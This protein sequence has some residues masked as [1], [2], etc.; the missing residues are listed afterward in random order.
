MDWG[1]YVARSRSSPERLRT[2][3][4]G[5]H[6]VGGSGPWERSILGALER[7]TEHGVRSTEHG[8]LQ[9][10]PKM[11]R[12]RRGTGLRPGERSLRKCPRSWSG[13]SCCSDVEATCSIRFKCELVAGFGDGICSEIRYSSGAVGSSWSPPH[14]ALRER[15]V[16]AP[17][18]LR[19]RSM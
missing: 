8:A 12:S 17:G 15:C 4:L 16:G 11:G 14:T 2:N 9:V 6:S 18:A 5:A 3:T 10:A 7:A 13:T 19:E 1:R